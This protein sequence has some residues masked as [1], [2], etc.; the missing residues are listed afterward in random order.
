MA[1]RRPI[2]LGQSPFMVLRP[3]K[4]ADLEILHQIDTACF[5]PG[6]SYS[7]EELKAFITFRNSRTWVAEEKGDIIGFLTAQ[8]T[9]ERSMHIITIDVEEKWRRCG[10]G[11]MLMD[12]AE[13]WGRGGGLKL[14]SL[15]TAEN[16]LPAQAFYR[17]RGYKK[18]GR[19]ERYYADGAPAW[20]MVKRLG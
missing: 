8:S 15:E 11:K 13:E 2:P 3:F 14:V 4:P 12:A 16:N 20:V 1:L 17:K 7:I 6:I 18:L 10:V 19:I 5:P 9:P